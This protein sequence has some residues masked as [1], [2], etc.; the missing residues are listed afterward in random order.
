MKKYI[1]YTTTAL[2]LSAAPVFAQVGSG[3][4]GQGRVTPVPNSA[5][6]P[7]ATS[8]VTDRDG[9]RQGPDSPNG[10]TPADANKPIERTDGGGSGDNEKG[11]AKT[12]KES[13]ET[14]A[15]EHFV[16]EAASGGTA[17]VE[18]GKLAAE[19]ATNERVKR[20]GQQMVADHGKANAELKTLAMKKRI[21]TDS[22]LDAKSQATHDRLSQLSGAAFDK[23]YIEEMVADHTKDVANFRNES[24]SG[25]D[26]DVKAC[27]AKTLPALEEHM[28]MVENIHESLGRPAV[29]TSGST[30]R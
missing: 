2:M 8:G 9:S 11:S 22:D 25:Q 12:A 16:R 17:E 26:A 24:R 28:K 15:D 1:A 18:L 27:A 30:P 4:S 3:T 20:F 6:Q 23:A 13:G 19:K 21:N 14:S 29:G 10:S 5:T 7:P